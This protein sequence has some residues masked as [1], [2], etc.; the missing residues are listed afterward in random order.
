MALRKELDDSIALEAP[1]ANEECERNAAPGRKGYC[2]ACYTQ[3]RRHGKRNCHFCERE[4]ILNYGRGNRKNGL[5]FAV[6]KKCH[7]DRKGSW[8]Y[9]FDK[10]RGCT[11]SKAGHPTRQGLCG[12]CLWAENQHGVRKCSCGNDVYRNFSKEPRIICAQCFKQKMQQVCQAYAAGAS[13]AKTA[14]GAGISVDLVRKIYT[15]LASKTLASFSL[16]KINGLDL[17]GSILAEA[18]RSINRKHLTPAGEDL[19]DLQFQALS[20]METAWASLWEYTEPRVMPWLLR[21]YFLPGGDSDDLRSVVKMGFVEA[22]RD[23]DATTGAPFIN[24]VRLTTRREVLQ[25]LTR[26]N[27]AFRKIN[28]YAQSLD[29]PVFDD[30]DRSYHEVIPSKYGDPTDVI[31]RESVSQLLGTLSDLESRVAHQI[32][33]HA[34]RFSYDELASALGVEWKSIDNAIQRI[35]RRARKLGLTVA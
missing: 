11:T 1:C 33:R 7:H 21:D 15:A 31:A 25:T 18:Y 24:F 4:L 17:G 5:S 20:G 23:W 35:R 16:P 8:T 34:G 27:R 6:C 28:R 32:I 13:L 3:L 2:E 29:E 10:C 14:A 12:E 26:E 30:P 19:R 22:V 9:F